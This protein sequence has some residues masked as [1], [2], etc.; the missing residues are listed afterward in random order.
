MTLVI[1][2]AALV[3]CGTVSLSLV[4]LRSV[5]AAPSSALTELLLSLRR[6]ERVDRTKVAVMRTT[7]ETWE[8][9]LARA[10]ADVDAIEKA[11]VMSEA[12][13]DLDTLYSSR[14]RWAAAALRIQVLGAVLLAAWAMIE[15]AR[16]AA[17]VSLLMG[18][19]GAGVI[20]QIG[21]RATGVEQEQR[22][23]VDQLVDLLAGVAEPATAGPAR[24]RSPRQHESR[25][26]R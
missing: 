13:H 3:S 7:A 5:A 15:V 25:A 19:A 9:R 24:R 6:T 14:D 16:V 11:D 10:L 12:I 17:A 26:R 21:R 1:V 2:A 22:R 8:G 18:L 4:Q 20:A 23:R